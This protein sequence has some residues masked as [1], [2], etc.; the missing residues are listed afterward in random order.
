MNTTNK[1]E[2]KM[3]NKTTAFVPTD[4][5]QKLIDQLKEQHLTPTKIMRWALDELDKVVNPKPKEK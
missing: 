1:K 2:K 3:A 5:N 4:E